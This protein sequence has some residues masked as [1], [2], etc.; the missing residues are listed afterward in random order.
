[1]YNKLD[2]ASQKEFKHEIR[3]AKQMP[4]EIKNQIQSAIEESEQ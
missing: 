1:M 2:N 4:P 3:E